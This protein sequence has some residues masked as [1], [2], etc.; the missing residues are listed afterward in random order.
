MANATKN[1]TRTSVKKKP[2]VIDNDIEKIVEVSE[3]ENIENIEDKETVESTIDNVS[4][5]IK[6][7]E[8]KREFGDNDDIECVSIC[9]GELGMIGIKSGINYR[10]A[11]RGD[12][13][14]VEYQ[15]LVA[16]LK[17]GKRQIYEPDFVIKNDDFLDKWP[18]IKKVYKN[19]YSIEDLSSVI[20]K[21]SNA[22]E[23]I[24]IIDSLPKGARDS[25]RSIAMSLINQ[26]KLDS[27]TKIKAL[28]KYYDTSFIL[29]SEF[30][31]K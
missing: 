28:D 30:K 23:M 3:T 8:K 27:I 15:D 21:S 25:V 5:S 4:Q 18:E 9:S 29:M 16:A 22:N 13:T 26:G 20:L 11:G 2:V 19:M 31:N 7:V 10:W 14:K 17:S 12:V 24:R 6:P 1:T